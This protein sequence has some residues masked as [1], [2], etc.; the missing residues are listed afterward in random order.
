MEFEIDV[1]G[2]D[3]LSK[4]YTICI[5]NKDSLIK[6]FKFNERLIKTL[7]S[8][9]GQ[10]IYRYKKSK[11]R[12]SLFKVRLYC[13]VIYYLFKSIRIESDLSL[14]ICKDFDGKENDI[15]ENLKFFLSKL[16]N[17]KLE[18]KIHFMKLNKD[19]NAHKYAF[20]MREDRKNKMDTY[21]K[22]ELKDIEKWLKK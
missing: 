19:S 1:S 13:I 16:L 10:E 22:L 7:S 17:L 12:R 11:K 20:L 6:G 5:A 8:K 9:Y 15:K 21:I 3:L 14:T 4:D 18:D 2:E